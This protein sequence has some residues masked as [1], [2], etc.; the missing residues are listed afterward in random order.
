MLKQQHLHNRRSNAGLNLKRFLCLQKRVLHVD[1]SRLPS[2]IPLF[3]RGTSNE[4][5]RPKSISFSEAFLSPLSSNVVPS[6]QSPRHR[7][8]PR[9]RVG[10]C[11]FSFSVYS[12]KQPLRTSFRKKMLACSKH[13]TKNKR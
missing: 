13:Q 4:M 11:F 5:E 3:L 9:Y 6:P 8:L 10:R 12:D 1:Q 2:R 7:C